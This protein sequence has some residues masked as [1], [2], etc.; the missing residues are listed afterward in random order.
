MSSKEFIVK[1]QWPITSSEPVPQIL[2]YSEDKTVFRLVPISQELREAMG[3]RPE[4][5]PELKR[6]F[7]ATITPSGNLLL[8][9][10]VAD[11]GW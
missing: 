1:V 10:R 3:G 7:R 4:R 11:P 5:E 2:I 8:G 6:F 9:N